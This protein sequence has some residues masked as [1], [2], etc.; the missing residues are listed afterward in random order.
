MGLLIFVVFCLIVLCSSQP[1]SIDMSK[2]QHVDVIQTID[3]YKDSYENS[4]F[5]I[6]KT[7]MRSYYR[8]K[9]RYIGTDMKFRITYITGKSTT[10]KARV[11]SEKC[12][13]LLDFIDAQEKQVMEKPSP[14][15][16]APPDSPKSSTPKPLQQ[17]VIEEK[18]QLVATLAAV[19]ETK[20]PQGLAISDTKT[21]PPKAA[22][23][24]LQDVYP[25][26]E[27][28]VGVTIPAGEYAIHSKKKSGSYYEVNQKQN[29]LFNGYAKGVQ[30]IELCEGDYFEFN[31]ATVQPMSN[32][33]LMGMNL[34][35]CSLKVGVHIPPG[36]YLLTSLN[37]KENP[38]SVYRSCRLTDKNLLIFEYVK[39]NKFVTLKHG[40][41]ISY[42]NC[43]IELVEDNPCSS[44]IDNKEQQS[45][46]DE[47]DDFFLQIKEEQEKKTTASPDRYTG[48][49]YGTLYTVGEDIPEGEYV[50]FSDSSK[51]V[52]I[53]VTPKRHK[54]ERVSFNFSGSCLLTLIQGDCF[55]ISNGYAMA[56]DK[57]TKIPMDS[58]SYMLK[59][60]THISSGTYLLKQ[61]YNS[62]FAVY[63]ILPNST[64]NFDEA[65]DSDAI[66]G[67]AELV[68][69]ETDYI[70]LENA[71]L[72]P[73]E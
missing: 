20:K 38:F 51:K 56:I 12:Q 7:G 4:G 36:E 72:E 64:M 28:K 44:D 13:R 49:Y 33:D 34:P 35:S 27:Y 11:G 68:L 37:A 29:I 15:P 63:Y 60:G 40:N 62:R 30:L 46:I 3:L 65:I 48:S 55:E 61:A 19:A 58:P 18:E 10:V 21:P 39:G 41:V 43:K 59:V 54:K 2:V 5:S 24:V 8:R 71:V 50:I 57:V 73:I 32:L 1:D 6:G 66:W 53:K 31:D 47:Q 25:A 17:P 69:N 26:G 16:V 23:P 14:K 67:S 45:T 9:K 42:E 22:P 70:Y 52:E